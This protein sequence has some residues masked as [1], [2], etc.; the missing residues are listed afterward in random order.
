MKMM[1]K[2]SNISTKILTGY[3]QK[4]LISR[5]DSILRDFLFCRVDDDDENL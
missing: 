5:M 1:K 4:E 2:F 3:F